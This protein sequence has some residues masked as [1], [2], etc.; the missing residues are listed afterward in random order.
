MLLNRGNTATRQDCEAYI[1]NRAAYDSGELKF[2]INKNIY[3]T[4]KVRN[5]LKALQ[6]AKCCYCEQKTSPGRIDHFR[7][8]GA[9]RQVK[10]GDKLH[11]GYY[12]LAYRWDNLVLACETCNLKKSDYFPLEEPGKRA[13]N[14]LDPLTSELPLLLNP[15]AETDLS[16]HLTFVGPACEPKTKRGRETVT[17]LELNRLELQETRQSV[18]SQLALL[19]VVV[20]DPGLSDVVRRKARRE[21]ESF[22]RPEAHYSAMARAYLST[23]HAYSGNIT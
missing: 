19:C 17:V 6:H 21:I 22:G 15:Y 4:Q 10:G 11:P 7:P 14:H 2:N 9:V 23:A 5:T 12:W 16:E 3:G 20:R 13:R 18:L 1:E 8:K